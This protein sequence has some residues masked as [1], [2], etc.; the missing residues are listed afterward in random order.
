VPVAH[1]CNPS[2]LGGRNQED[3][4]SKPSRQIVFETLSQKYPSQ[5][6]IGG[7]AQSVGS[8]FKPQYR[9][10][11]K[12]T[13]FRDLGFLGNEEAQGMVLRV[14]IKMEWKTKFLGE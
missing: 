13:H 4:S 12:K 9:K 3:H 1:A 6:R 7:V 2:Y 5:K 8:E 14:G 11:K 10:K